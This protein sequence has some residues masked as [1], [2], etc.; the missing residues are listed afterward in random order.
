MNIIEFPTE[1]LDE[2]FSH[3]WWY[4]PEL[5]LI[6]QF[7]RIIVKNN[8]PKFCIKDKKIKTFFYLLAAKDE[9]GEFS[10]AAISAEIKL[11]WL[12]IIVKMKRAE[13]NNN[14]DI[15]DK[16]FKN[17]YTLISGSTEITNSFLVEKLF[18]TYD[19]NH[20]QVFNIADIA[21]YFDCDKFYT[22]LT[23][24]KGHTLN[25][26][27]LLFVIE[28]NFASAKHIISIEPEYE[29]KISAFL[30]LSVIKELD[31]EENSDD[32]ITK[33]F[34]ILNSPLKIAWERLRGGSK[35]SPKK[36]SNLK[37]SEKNKDRIVFISDRIIKMLNMLLK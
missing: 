29:Q 26:V 36:D 25:T 4:L 3:I 31:I 28:G 20:L 1:I 7:F 17:I 2:I 22:F 13:D 18:I 37:R 21:F 10:K 9:N 30:M 33:W 19:H 27:M 15:F 34:K 24:Q 32:Y 12:R 16:I 14:V 11:D 8:F 23:K 5:S 6:C 35:P